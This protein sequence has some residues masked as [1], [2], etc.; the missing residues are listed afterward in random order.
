MVPGTIVGAGV[1][2]NKQNHSKENTKEPKFILKYSGARSVKPY[3]H[4]LCHSQIQVRLCFVLFCCF[5]M[6][7]CF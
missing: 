4:S 6:I 7:F 3:C 2:V 5:K 1:T